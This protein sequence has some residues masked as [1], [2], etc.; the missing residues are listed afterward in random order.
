MKQLVVKEL[1]TNELREKIIEEKNQYS[2]LK[3]HHAVSS[4]ENPLKI[5]VTRRTIAR[6]VTELKKREIIE[7]K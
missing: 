5:R 4:I 6:L 2:K 3:S 1:S 7:K